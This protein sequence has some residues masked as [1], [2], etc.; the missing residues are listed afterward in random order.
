MPGS[1]RRRQATNQD[2]KNATTAYNANDESTH[3]KS[4]SSV[5]LVGK[6]TAVKAAIKNRTKAA[7]CGCE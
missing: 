7:G 6:N 3:H 4:D 1:I 2:G 5:S